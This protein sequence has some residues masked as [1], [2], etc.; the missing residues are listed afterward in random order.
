MAYLR[1]HVEPFDI[2]AHEEPRADRI[3]LLQPI[4]LRLEI[5]DLDCRIAL[6][7]H[8]APRPVEAARLLDAL[9]DALEGDRPGGRHRMKRRPTAAVDEA[10][11]E[12]EEEVADESLLALH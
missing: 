12:M 6:R 5:D 10:A 9:N 4:R 7:E 8:D 1:A 3:K 2:A 11:R